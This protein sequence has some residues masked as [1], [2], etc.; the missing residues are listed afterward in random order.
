[1]DSI[2]QPP[3]IILIGPMGSGKTTLG[4]LLANQLGY[5]FC[6][7][8]HEIERRTGA[9]I[10]WIFDKEGEA[11]FRERETRVID[12]LT[13]R[14]QLIL[15]TGGGAVVTP[16]N[17]A[18]L[19]RGL[20]IYLRASVDVQFERTSRDR[21][22]PLLQ[23]QNPKERLAEIFALRDPIYQQLADITVTTGYLSPKKMVQEIISSLC[24]Q[25]IELM[26]KLT[27]K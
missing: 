13:Q 22:R 15:A 19:K 23:T 21:N 20:V 27:T 25:G 26:L 10:S 16:R 3:L 8:D 1:M 12:Q 11:G 17:H 18:L 2:R 24:H 7:S 6:D 9:S 14:Q 4:K 5:N